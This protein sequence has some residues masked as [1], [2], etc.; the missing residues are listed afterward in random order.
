MRS[1]RDAALKAG[2]ET[3]LYFVFNIVDTSPA[4]G[5]CH[6][7]IKNRIDLGPLHSLHQKDEAKRI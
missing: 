7:I 5:G 1:S 4:S 6:T 2:T 3:I